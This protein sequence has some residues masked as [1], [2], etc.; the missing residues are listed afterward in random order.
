MRVLLT[1]GAGDLATVLSARLEAR[2]D[3]AVRLDIAAPRDTRGVYVAG[4]L[5]DR[6]CLRRAVDDSDCVVH[7]AA[8]H[9]IHE[10]TRQKD[11]YAFWQLNVTGTFYVFEAAVRAGVRH[12]VYISS[13]SIRDTTSLYG[14]S[15]VLGEEIARTYAERHGMQVIV[16]RPRGFIPSWNTAVYSS[17][18][19][20]LQWFW[21]GAVH[22]EDVAQAVMQSME[23]AQSTALTGALTLVVDG[24]YEYTTADLATWDHAG[25]GST[26]RKY[27]A[28]YEALARQHGLVPEVPPYKYDIT[29]TRRWL[30]YVP[31]YSLRNALMELDS[32]GTAGPPHP[33]V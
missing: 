19:E 14:H 32:Y 12:M 29:E 23:L 25:P 33:Y 6:A 3:T 16:L 21:R 10:S 18:V 2:G 9:G 24:A 17:F 7:I 11:A 30:G 13:T 27:Y 26:F 28:P 8:W 4:S 15:K 22:I 1:G 20:W 5:L 31:T